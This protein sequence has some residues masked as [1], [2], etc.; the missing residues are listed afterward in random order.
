M[1]TKTAA[2]SCFNEKKVM[3]YMVKLT[4]RRLEL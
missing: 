3:S 1:E 4:F 2:V